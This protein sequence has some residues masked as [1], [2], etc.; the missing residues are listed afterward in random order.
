M[1]PKTHNYKMYVHVENV[2]L[3]C[4]LIQLAVINKDRHTAKSI[5]FK[6]IKLGF[7]K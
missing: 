2:I 6:L 1:F 7:T 5:K 3:K 4:V